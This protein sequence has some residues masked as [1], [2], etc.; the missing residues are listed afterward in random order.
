MENLKQKLNKYR[1]PTLL[2][3]TVF[4]NIPEQVIDNLS[5]DN[6]NWFTDKNYPSNDCE[7][8]VWSSKKNKYLIE[9][10]DSE[11][12]QRCINLNYIKW[13]QII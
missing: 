8:I 3:G 10:T 9:F 13:K 4:Y 2:N 12:A 7:I 1:N 11:F 5:L 6:W